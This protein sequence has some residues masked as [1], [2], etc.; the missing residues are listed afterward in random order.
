MGHLLLIHLYFYLFVHAINTLP[1]DVS[2]VDAR[3]KEM[4]L[5]EK[6]SVNVPMAPVLMAV[7]AVSAIIG[8]LVHDSCIGCQLDCLGQKDHDDCIR[9]PWVDMDHGT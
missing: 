9:L 7:K 6:S 4:E 3:E 1:K 5:K 2:M 8:E